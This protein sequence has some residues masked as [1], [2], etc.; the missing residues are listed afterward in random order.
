DSD[1]KT[2]Q[3]NGSMQKNFQA[4]ML[5]MLLEELPR[6]KKSLQKA[7]SSLD[8]SAL[9]E[10]AHKMHGA[11]AYCDIP[12]LQSA[13]ASLE[14]A[15]KSKDMEQVEQYIDSVYSEIDRLLR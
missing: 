4:H 1:Q 12:Q 15:T 2:V 5:N 7:L 8:I 3:T 11:V 13:L 10:T 14:A 9:F 6:F